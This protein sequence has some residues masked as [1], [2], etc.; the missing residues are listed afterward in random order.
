MSIRER[1]VARKKDAQQVKTQI[2]LAPNAKRDYKLH[3]V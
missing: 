3:L 1:K 2:E